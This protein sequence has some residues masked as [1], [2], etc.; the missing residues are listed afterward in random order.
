MD[1]QNE[2]AETG[3]AVRRDGD[4]QSYFWFVGVI[5]VHSGGV[6][7]GN[8]VV[9]ARKPISAGVPGSAFGTVRDH[10]Q[11][12]K[13]AEMTKACKDCVFWNGADSV[14]GYVAGQCRKNA[15]T[16]KALW[17]PTFH[18]DWCGEFQGEPDPSV[19]APPMIDGALAGEQL[20]EMMLKLKGQ[21]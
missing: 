20:R 13:G 7:K 16:A 5:R 17:P 18:G 11:I 4:N 8:E 14:E 2:E 9:C 12:Q 15:P 6:F 10:I 3:Q 1:T 19:E 21:E